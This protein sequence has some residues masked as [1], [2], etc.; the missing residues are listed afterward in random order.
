M[1]EVTDPTVFTV[2]DV[3]VLRD[4]GLPEV[5]AR[6]PVV[7][8]FLLMDLAYFM[9]A[10]LIFWKRS[11]DGMALLVSFVLVFLGAII[12]SYAVEALSR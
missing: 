1:A 9:V 10:A 6:G 2:E 7:L 11:N 3:A 8:L 4:L 12:L 5:L